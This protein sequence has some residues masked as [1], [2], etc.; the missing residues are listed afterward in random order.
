MLPG[1]HK[2][3]WRNDVPDRTDFRLAVRFFVSEISGEKFFDD[4]YFGRRYS[5]RRSQY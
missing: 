2:D 1:H 4:A 3:A 5:H